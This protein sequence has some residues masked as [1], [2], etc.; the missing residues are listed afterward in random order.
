MNSK[1][2]LMFNTHS[3]LVGGVKRLLDTMDDFEVRST[4]FTDEIALAREIEQTKPEIVIMDDETISLIEPGRLL[5]LF[6][7]V[8]N[9]R[10]IVLDRQISRMDVYDKRELI[11]SHPNHF[12]EALV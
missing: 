7:I 2:I 4:L 12:I 3:L 6:R 9:L 11:I 10:L 1:C 8:P 5:E